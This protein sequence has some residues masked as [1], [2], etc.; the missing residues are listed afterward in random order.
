MLNAVMSAMLVV[1]GGAC[2]VAGYVIGS[3]RQR[4][5]LDAELEQD[6]LDSR[7]RFLESPREPAR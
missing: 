1:A 4:R 6:E 7:Q 2:A 5:I 3:W